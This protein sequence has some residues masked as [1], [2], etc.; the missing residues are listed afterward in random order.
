MIFCFADRVFTALG[1]SSDGRF[2]LLIFIKLQTDSLF[3]IYIDIFLTL[4]A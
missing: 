3:S 2:P 1:S 4:R